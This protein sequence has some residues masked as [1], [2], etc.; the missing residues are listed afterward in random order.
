MTLRTYE[1]DKDIDSVTNRYLP[2]INNLFPVIKFNI[3]IFNF[4]IIDLNRSGNK[5]MIETKDDL[6]NEDII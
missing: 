2:H 1:N 6:H 5:H 4:K 3:W